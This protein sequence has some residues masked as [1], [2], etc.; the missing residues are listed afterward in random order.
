[1]NSSL[2]PSASIGRP[3][4]IPRRRFLQSAAA[5]AAGLWLGAPQFLRAQDGPSANDKLNIGVVGVGGQG[6]FSIGQLKSIANLVA[7]CDVDEQHLNAAAQQ[8]PGAKTYRDFRRLIDQKDLDAIVVATPDHT[9]AVASVAALKSGRHL[10]CEKP[11]AR[12]ISE[13]RIVTETARRLKRVTQIGTQI[14]AGTN[15]RRV[16]ELIRS[17]AIGDVTEV[18]VWVAAVYGGHDLYKDTPEVP[19]N[20][21]WKLWLGPVPD[22]PYHPEY[23]H[24]KWRNWWAFGGGSLADFGCHYMD[25]PFWAL[26]L[27]HPVS[28]EAEGPPVH[29]HSTPPWLIVRYEFPA[30]VYHGRHSPPVNLTWYHGG[31]YPESIGQER[32]DKWKSGVLFVGKKGQLIADYGRH[33]L[34]PE[35]EFEGFAKPTPFIQNSVGH[36]LEWVHAIKVG[37][38]TTC[39]FD[40]SGPLTETALLGNVAFRV[41]RKLAWDFEKMKALNCPEADRYIQHEYRTGWSI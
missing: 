3:S 29:P 35:K 17:D 26:D 5:S 18:H 14:H 36:H 10:Y 19:P 28:A 1:M 9:H 40:Y 41:G 2:R 16:V 30:R 27:H 8:F 20:L 38:S 25:L 24:F 31:K 12:T 34:L 39:R 32:F 13:A 7:L 23:A 21:D 6:G 15:Y 22:H 11:L 33:Q 4:R 37:G